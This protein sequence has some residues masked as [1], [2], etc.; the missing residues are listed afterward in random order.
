MLTLS[1]A[2]KA[3]RLQEFIAQEEGRG[4]GPVDRAK[5]D[6][7]LAMSVKE[8][9]SKGRTSRSSSAGGSTEK[10]TPQGSG[11]DASR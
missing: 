3:G 6:A 8:P 1:A 2:I 9:Q 7:L 5:F 10:K 4:I 11:R